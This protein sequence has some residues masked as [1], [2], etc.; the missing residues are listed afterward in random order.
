MA[1]RSRIKTDVLFLRAPRAGV[2]PFYLFFIS[3]MS[4]PSRVGKSMNDIP[5]ADENSNYDSGL[6]RLTNVRIASR[7]CVTTLGGGGGGEKPSEF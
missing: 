6:V 4:C 2:L 7:S 1:S 3:R 5:T